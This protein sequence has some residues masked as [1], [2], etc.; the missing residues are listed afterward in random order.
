MIPPSVDVPGPPGIVMV[1]LLVLKVV[2]V[3]KVVNGPPGIVGVVVKT[4]AAV[5]E[6]VTGVQILFVTV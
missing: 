3:V 4:P 6:V 5:S 2:G 1:I